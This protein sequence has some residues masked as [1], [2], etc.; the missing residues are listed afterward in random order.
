MSFFRHPSDIFI[1][2]I[3]REG[4]GAKLDKKFIHNDDKDK[5][6]FLK[7]LDEKYGFSLENLK[8]KKDFMDLDEEFL[9]V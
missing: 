9:N 6:E 3:V 8:T 7:W 2:V 4:N 1:E 5:I